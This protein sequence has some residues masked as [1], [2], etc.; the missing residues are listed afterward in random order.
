LTGLAF[1]AS[2]A[3]LARLAPL[4]SLA[5]VGLAT[6]SREGFFQ[7]VHGCFQGRYVD[8][9]HLAV[10]H[11]RKVDGDLRL[12]GKGFQSR[13]DV[14]QVLLP[15]NLVLTC[16]YGPPPESSEQL[17]LPPEQLQ[18]HCPLVWQVQFL[19]LHWLMLWQV[20]QELD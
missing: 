4:T 11:C 15:Y 8:F 1:L 6:V 16:H 5:A 9:L 13:L 17:Q 3:C 10:V 2:L 14:R 7:L 12:C 19:E 20:W 18:S